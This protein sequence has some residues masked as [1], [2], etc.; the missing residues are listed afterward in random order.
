MVAAYRW[1]NSP[2]WL[3]WSEGLKVILH[4]LH[5]LSELS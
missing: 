3:A 1:T 2:S 5:E 4:S